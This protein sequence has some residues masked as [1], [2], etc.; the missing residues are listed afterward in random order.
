VAEPQ[1]KPK[2]I[3]GWLM[4]RNS[5]GDYEVEARAGRQEALIRVCECKR[6]YQAQL[7]LV[8]GGSR[9]FATIEAKTAA[10]ALRRLLSRLPVYVPQRLWWELRRAAGFG[11]G[12]GDG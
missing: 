9:S 5:V 6:S 1:R 12:G 8:F 7:F 11:N 10:T 3:A 4:H 2:R